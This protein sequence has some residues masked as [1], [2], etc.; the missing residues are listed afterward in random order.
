MLLVADAVPVDL[1]TLPSWLDA[2]GTMGAVLVAVVAFWREDQREKKQREAEDAR[3][4]GYAYA[5]RRQ[6]EKWLEEWPD[7]PDGV[8][9]HRI[10]GHFDE[11]E[12][13]ATQMVLLAPAGSPD[14]AA[15]VRTVFDLFYDARDRLSDLA[16]DGAD[17]GTVDEEFSTAKKK[18]RGCASML[19]EIIGDRYDT[20]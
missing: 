1:G 4:A 5:L 7:D 19:D 8:V 15:K 20:R 3:I 17:R 18:L 16:E 12:H 14:I 2:A 13:R 9:A 6:L 11:A 10:T